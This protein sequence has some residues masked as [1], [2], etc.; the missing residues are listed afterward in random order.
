M[1]STSWLFTLFALL[2]TAAMSTLA[3]LPPETGKQSNF[4]KSLNILSS[5]SA[6]TAYS[7]SA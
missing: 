6:P 3:Q 1:K 2:L 5:A 4:Q 7:F